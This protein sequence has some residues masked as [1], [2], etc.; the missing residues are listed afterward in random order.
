M[1]SI[2]VAELLSNNDGMFFESIDSITEVT[3][4][5]NPKKTP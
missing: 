3:M 5:N 4:Q 2:P 1:V